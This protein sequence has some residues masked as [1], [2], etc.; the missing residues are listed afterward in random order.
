MTFCIKNTLPTQQLNY[1]EQG[2][3]MSSELFQ[4]N[5]HCSVL[6]SIQNLQML[7]FSTTV[8]PGMTQP[9]IANTC[10]HGLTPSSRCLDASL[11]CSKRFL[12]TP[13]IYISTA[14]HFR[15]AFGFICQVA[16][17]CIQQGGP[18]HGEI[19]KEMFGD[20]IL[21]SPVIQDCIPGS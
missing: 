9:D 3:T 19:K 12:H 6:A 20:L 7:L 5:V 8:N 11:F 15:L 4:G 21:H 10:R 16:I 2:I 17:T 18:A 13:V 1:H 14:L